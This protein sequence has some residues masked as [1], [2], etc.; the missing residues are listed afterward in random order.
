MMKRAGMVMMGAGMLL[1]M[2]WARM[3]RSGFA[4][5]R[6]VSALSAANEWPGRSG[7]ASGGMANGERAGGNT[8]Q[9]KGAGNGV[10]FVSVEGNDAN[11]GGSWETAKGG[12]D[13]GA[14]INAAER[15]L[16]QNGG[17]IEVGAGTYSLATQIVLVRHGVRVEC[18]GQSDYTND[19]NGACTVK[20]AAGA[21]AVL[22]TGA[23]DSLRGLHFESQST[24]AGADDCV[25][26]EGQQFTVDHVTCEGFGRDGFRWDSTGGK[27]ADEWLIVFAQ[28]LSVRGSG[29]DFAGTGV[30]ANAGTCVFCW[31]T[32]SG[33]YGF[34]LGSGVSADNV[35]LHT[36]AEF[37][38]AGD[39]NVDT[40]GNTFADA[41]CESGVGNTATLGG[42]EN[43][44]KT[45]YFGACKVK[46]TGAQ[47]VIE[48]LTGVFNGQQIF[49][50]G[51]PTIDACGGEASIRGNNNAFAVTTGSGVVDSCT[52]NFAAPNF[53]APPTCTVSTNS[54]RAIAT[55]ADVSTAAVRLR[56]SASL[57][58]GRVYVQCF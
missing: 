32:G 39:Y 4:Q 30:D 34:N 51:T 7:W 33:G 52:V 40:N 19:N 35:F 44:F 45:P 20:S 12:A 18:M 53:D 1:C 3:E 16:P 54:T 21:G 48:N 41:Y 58:R 15:A 5:A 37:N 57:E 43:W 56:F 50:S 42:R 10:Q 17:L 31:A 46:N 9:K 6:A 55:I 26:I 49:T 47:N 29:F 23:Y 25:L 11:D 13:I 2:A 24:G 38:R 22:V 36:E 27:T 28:T 14:A 8:A